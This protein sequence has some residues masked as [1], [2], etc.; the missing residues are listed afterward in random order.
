MT[1]PEERWEVVVIGGGPAG[2]HGALQ[3]GRAGRRVLL[4][5]RERRAGGECVYRGTIPS[6][7]LRET[8]VTLGRLGR[9]LP[10][11]AGTTAAVEIDVARV[12]ARLDGVL[13]A[14]HEFLAR[15]LDQGGVVRRQGRARFVGPHQL[16]LRAPGGGVSRIRF[17]HALIATGS[18]PREPRETPIDHEYVLDSDS[19]L[20][21]P[22][23]PRSLI[24]LGGGV[25]ASEFASIFA[26]LGC[27]VTL[28]DRGA[29]PLGFMD[30][31]LT[32]RFLAAFARAGGTFVAGATVRGVVV[33]PLSGVRVELSTGDTLEADKVLVALGRVASLDGLGLEA[34]GLAPGPRG[35]LPVD[36][37]GRTALEHVYAA[38]DV[39]GPPALA[40]TSMEQGRRAMCHALGLPA[41]AG[42][43]TVPVGIYTIPEM[44]S[45]GLTEA[46]ATERFGA[47]LVGRAEHTELARAH[48]ED[49]TEG[50]LKLVADESG[51]RLLGAHAVGEGS[52][53]LV[54]LAQ[55]AMLGG[56]GVDAFVENAMNFPTRAEAYRIAALDLVEQRRFR[57]RELSRSRRPPRPSST[58]RATA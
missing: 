31:E 1:E 34:L 24:V 45:V 35:H 22:F 36:P 13:A 37:H 6:K 54:H 21:L 53:E 7:T 3:A 32:D 33:E 44:A 52:T 25:I 23:L 4:V 57:A 47:A 18:R 8:A 30:P 15:Q 40:A 2:M 28:V 20:R 27:R 41:G 48:I 9:R 58:P 11:L 43:A 46:E 51:T 55:L 5:D 14:H 29:R 12:T 38:G 49:E 26:A 56:L 50:L 19:I 42:S 39:I 16:E 17:D 10:E